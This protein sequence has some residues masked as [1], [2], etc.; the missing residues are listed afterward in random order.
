MSSA[1]TGWGQPR[2][3]E[4]SKEIYDY[5]ERAERPMKEVSSISYYFDYIDLHK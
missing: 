5:V 4:T 3:A 2:G 1:G